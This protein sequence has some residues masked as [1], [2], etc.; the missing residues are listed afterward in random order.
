MQSIKRTQTGCTGSRILKIQDHHIRP[1]GD[2][3]V[4]VCPR[5]HDL[6]HIRLTLSH[7]GGQGLAGQFVT[8][9]NSYAHGT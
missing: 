7:E 1:S 6:P 2:S 9:D 3:L 4:R 5:V 8:V